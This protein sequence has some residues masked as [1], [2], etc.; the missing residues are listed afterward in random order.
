MSVIRVMRPGSRGGRHPS[1]MVSWVSLASSVSVT[2][3]R[4]ELH[5][6]GSRAAILAVGALALKDIAAVRAVDRPTP[7]APH[8]K[9]ALTE[10]RPT[11]SGVAD[12]H[13]PVAI[14][15]ARVCWLLILHGGQ[16]T[17]LTWQPRPN[18]GKKLR[19]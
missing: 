5:Q 2:R 12:C 19:A 13:L 11:S 18:D 7:A 3:R 17:W 1:V 4:Y 8:L 6:D 16:Y 9:D 14:H 15:V 10:V